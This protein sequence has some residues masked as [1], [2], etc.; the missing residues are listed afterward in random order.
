MSIL[1]LLECHVKAESVAEFKTFMQ[2]ELP[3]TRSFAGYQGLTLH[4]NLDDGQNFVFVERWDSRDAYQR[5]LG[6][7]Q[8]NGTLAQLGN[9][10]EAAP[11]IRFFDDVAA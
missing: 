2:A 8:S 6:W 4:S 7:R 1:V 5:Y 9:L 10:L 3:H 11:T